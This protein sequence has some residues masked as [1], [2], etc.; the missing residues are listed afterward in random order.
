MSGRVKLTLAALEA[1]LSQYLD[2][3]KAIREIPTLWMLTQPAG[4][5]VRKAELLA[6]G[7]KAL[8]N[9]G[10]TI[11]VQNEASQ[12]GGGA[13]P[14]SNLPTRAVCLSHDRLSAQ[15]IEASLRLG[16]PAIIT[17]IKEG[18]VLFDP[19]TLNDEEIGK[20]VDAV[21]NMLQESVV[22]RGYCS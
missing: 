14:L 12:T 6:S 3:D 4:E 8:E 7:L 9:R 15:Q 17:R 21:K 2:R 19:R 5:I 22:R 1:T 18:L 13:L 11:T 16:K 10:L 20:I